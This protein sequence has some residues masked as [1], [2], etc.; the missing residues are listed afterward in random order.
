MD[1]LKTIGICLLSI[2]LFASEVVQSKNLVA[3]EKEEPRI[4][5]RQIVEAS[6]LFPIEVNV[7]DTI[8]SMSQFMSSMW[9]TASSYINGGGEQAAP[10]APAAPQYDEVDFNSRPISNYGA[11]DKAK[12]RKK[13]K[14]KRKNQAIDSEEF[15]FANV[16]ELF[17]F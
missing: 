6:G 17:S 1:M 13:K 4:F 16:L 11:G 10:A 9:D 7:P 3:I 5:F 12:R 2:L 14:V 15:T 8:S